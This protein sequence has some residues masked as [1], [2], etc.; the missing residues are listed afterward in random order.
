MVRRRAV[1]VAGC[2]V[3]VV[4]VAVVLGALVRAALE[5]CWRRPWPGV[6]RISSIIRIIVALWVVVGCLVGFCTKLL[7]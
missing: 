2:I 5:I 4:V 7:L 6:A 1:A 3:V